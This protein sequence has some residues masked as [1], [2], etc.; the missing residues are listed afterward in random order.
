M[1]AVMSRLHRQ[2]WLVL[3]EDL[4]RHNFN[5]E[6]KECKVTNLYVPVLVDFLLVF[7][8]CHQFSLL[9]FVKPQA[10]AVPVKYMLLIFLGLLLAFVRLVC[11]TCIL[12]VIICYCH[13]VR[14]VVQTVVA[15]KVVFSAVIV[16]L[17]L[18]LCVYCQYCAVVMNVGILKRCLLTTLTPH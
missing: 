13:S 1:T 4:R 9:L 5:N 8:G 17:F 10:A 3:D 12:N 7:I 14:K 15:L 11:W 18:V 16:L 2:W 6:A